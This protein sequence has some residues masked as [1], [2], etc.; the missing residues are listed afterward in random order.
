MYRKG[1]EWGPKETTSD[2]FTLT[3]HKES[4]ILPKGAMQSSMTSC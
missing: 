4:G 1:R 3:T 2:N